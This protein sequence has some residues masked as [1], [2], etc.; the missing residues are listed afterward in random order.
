MGYIVVLSGGVGGVKLVFGLLKV[1]LLD[2]LIIIVNIGD[3]FEYFGLLI[4]FDIDM[5]FYILLGFNDYGKGWGC[6][7]EIWLFFEIM[8]EFGGEV[9]FMLGDW[10]F[11]LYVF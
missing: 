9:W 6:V 11:V 4:L 7:D 2:D 1:L 8:K 3:D 5:L 10:D